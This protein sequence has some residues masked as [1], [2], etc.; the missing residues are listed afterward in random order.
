MEEEV[1]EEINGKFVFVSIKVYVKSWREK[2]QE[3]WRRRRED[4]K[5]KYTQVSLQEN[6][7]RLW[8][9]RGRWEK[10]KLIKRPHLAVKRWRRIEKKKAEEEKGREKWPNV[11]VAAEGRR[12]E[13]GR[14]RE[15]RVVFPQ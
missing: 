15:G 1:V 11:F 12:G 8:K 13:G 6:I 14:G 5:K 9:E 10:R 2:L 7:E 4:E 3:E